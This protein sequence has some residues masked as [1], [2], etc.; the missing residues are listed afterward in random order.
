MPQRSSLMVPPNILAV[1]PGGTAVVYPSGA[2]S[3]QNTPGTS[4]AWSGYTQIVASLGANFVCCGASIAYTTASGLEV[5]GAVELA[6]GAASSEVAFERF[7]YG[8]YMSDSTND[9]SGIVTA[10]QLFA[11]RYIASGTRLSYRGAIS[12]ATGSTQRIWL[13]GYTVPSPE[14]GAKLIDGLQWV[15]GHAAKGGDR[16]PNTDFTSVT[17]S[18]TAWVASGWVEVTA[19][20]ADDLLVTGAQIYGTTGSREWIIEYGVGAAGSEIV[21]PA[22]LPAPY[23]STVLRASYNHVACPLPLFVAKGQRLAVRAYGNSTTGTVK[24]A[25][26][27]EY[28]K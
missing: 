17:H 13:Y 6:E 5:Y 12:S 19:S 9:A 21:L 16:L 11:P 2:S 14:I 23:S 3:I 27:V 1:A 26:K 20:A 22:L 7:S 10:S 24:V 15:Q 8:F 18:G 4:W 28:L 25:T